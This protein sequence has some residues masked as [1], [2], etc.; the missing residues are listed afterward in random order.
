VGWELFGIIW[1]FFFENDNGE[2]I[3]VTAKGYIAM[4]QNFLLHQLEAIGIDPNNL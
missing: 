3:T 4:L 1:P 2:T